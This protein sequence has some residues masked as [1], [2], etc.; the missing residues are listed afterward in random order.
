MVDL[1]FFF[2]SKRSGSIHTAI[3][4][5]RKLVETKVQGKEL[6]LML[7]CLSY[8]LLQNSLTCPINLSTLWH[9]ICLAFERRMAE[10]IVSVATERIADLLIHEALFLNDVGQEVESLKAELERM[11][12]FLKDVDRKQ[13]QDE[14]LRNRVRE[15]RDLAYD[16]EDVI[17]SYILKVAHRRGFHGFIKRFTTVF[18]THKMGKQVKD[19][20]TK[21][22]DISKTLPTYGISG[23]GEGSNSAAEMQHRLRRSYPHVEEDDV[24]SLEVSTRDVMDQLMKKEDRL[25]VVSIVGMGGIGKT[26]LAKKV[27]N[28]NDVK[29][30]FDCCAWVFISQQCKPKEVLHGVLIKVL[31]PSIKDRELIDKLKEDE[32][33]EKLYDVLKEKR[34]LVVFDDIWK[35]E[36]W[37]SLKPA[38]PKGNEGSKLLFTTRNKEVAM[39][40]DPRSSPIELPFLTGDESWTLFKRKALPENKMESHACSKEFAMLG[41][42]MLKKCGGLPLAIVVLGGLLATKKSWTEWEMVQKNINAYLNKVQQQEYGGVNGILALSYNELPFHLKPCFLYLGHYPEDSEIS[43]TELI[44]LWIA[45]GFISPSLEGREM[46][47]EDVAEQYLVELINRCLVQVSRWDHTGTNVKTCRIHDLLRDLCVSKAGKENFFGIIQPPMNG[48]ENHSLDLTVATVPKVR[49]IAVYPSKRYLGLTCYEVV[50]PH[51]FGKLKNLH[52]LFI[53]VDEPAKIPNVL[54]KLQRLRHLVL[55]GNWKNLQNNWPEI[56]RCCQVNSLKNIETLKYVRIENLTENNALLKLTN[57][58]SLG[59]QFGRSEDV[60]AILKSPSFG[61]HRLRS[62]RMEL[63]GSIPFPEL[64]QLSQCHHLSKLLLDGQIQED[65]NSSHHVLEF[66]PTNICKLTLWSSCINEDP[67]PVLEKLPHLRILIF[68]SSSYTGTKMSCSVNGFPQLDSLE[69]YGSNLAEWQIEEGAMPCLRSLYLATVPGLKMVPEGLRYITTLQ[70]LYLQDMNR[71]LG[72]RIRVRD[73]REGEDFY[74]VRHV[75]SIQII[76]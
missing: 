59:I 13:E 32:L 71:S 76:S 75:L 6:L 49:R 44:R 17:D 45:E 39:I 34:Y 11:K 9:F 30:Y 15:I 23:E 65:T 70:E 36:D 33:V 72:E 50:L 57:I 41:K 46:L 18:I 1:F 24:V 51:S 37:E 19:I 31:T 52:T 74:K 73:G 22:G 47:M 56:Q 66:L 43:K 38:F 69:I 61:L 5:I 8:F 58:R 27:Y 3:A 53:Q 25:H 60:E 68:Q 42:E 2:F 12:S 28:H 35:C 16:A 4:Y 29:K 63:E 64:E 26:T 62:L 7:I 10:A 55:T 21:L 48:N 54:S 67:M 14:R 40:A 20:Q